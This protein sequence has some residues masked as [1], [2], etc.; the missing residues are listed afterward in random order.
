M[1]AQIHFFVIQ[2][3]RELHDKPK[4]GAENFRRQ[5]QR[6]ISASRQFDCGFSSEGPP[7]ESASDRQTCGTK[8]KIAPANAPVS[9]RNSANLTDWISAIGT[10][11]GAIAALIALAMASQQI[12]GLVSQLQ[13]GNFASLMMLEVEMNSRKQRVDEAARD[14]Q[15]LVH[16]N[17]SQEELEIFREYLKH[18]IE[19]W[20]NLVDRFAFCIRKQMLDEDDFKQEYRRYIEELVGSLPQYFT[21]ESA[22]DNVIQLCKR[23]NINLPNRE[24]AES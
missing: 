18:C 6:A 12:R 10:L 3:W 4:C 1:V 16:E 11:I 22:Y 7:V 23:W 15:K 2:Q 9:N 19:N 8:E 17:R 13:Q 5:G 14:L 24:A 20:L 21:S